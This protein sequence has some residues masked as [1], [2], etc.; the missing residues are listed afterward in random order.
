MMHSFQYLSLVL[1]SS[2]TLGACA[3]ST[4]E[5]APAPPTLTSAETQ[6]LLPPSPT[7]PPPAP[8]QTA[9]IV[10]TPTAIPEPIELVDGLGREVMLPGPA[11]RIVSLAPS[12]TEILFAIGAGSQVVGRDSFS[13]YPEA[14]QQITDIGGG[15]G[16]L[17]FETIVSLDPD[18]VLAAGLT[19]ADQVQA[20]ADLGITVYLLANPVDFDGLYYNLRIVAQLSNHPSEAEQVISDIQARFD[21]IMERLAGVEEKPLVFYELDGTDPNAPWISG[22]GTFIDTLITLAG[23]INL[24]RDLEGEWV[25]ISLEEIIAQDPDII[26]LGDAVWGG[27]TPEAVAARAGW[28]SLSAVQK[29]RVYPFDDNLVSRPGP[30]LIAGLEAMAKLLHPE[31][32]Q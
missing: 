2:I 13:D 16:E 28:E 30:R 10:L 20:L 11:Q 22:P 12:N 19:P 27:V 7:L 8:S 17:D 23:G 4:L 5:V 3:V 6:L 32:F 21:V 25:Q 15:F 31:L 18:L 9:T 24:G 29:G 26:L 1:L 14:A